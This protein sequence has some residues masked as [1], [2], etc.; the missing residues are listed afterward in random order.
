M[1]T[2][3]SSELGWEVT[4][5]L[6]TDFLS[7]GWGSVNDNVGTLPYWFVMCLL[8]NMAITWHVIGYPRG[9]I[10]HG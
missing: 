2:C 4:V 6:P 8:V 7:L 9:M 5:E 10:C 3:Q 1:V